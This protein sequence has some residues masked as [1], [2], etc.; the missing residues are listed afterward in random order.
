MTGK[1]ERRADP[2]SPER[3]VSAATAILDEGGADA[4]SFRALAARLSTGSGAIYWH[5]ADKQAL[6]TAATDQVIARAM[7][8]EGDGLSPDE[9]IRTL[10]LGVFDA[11]D[12]HPWVG[13]QLAGDPW[14]H[15]VL[16]ILEGLGAQVTA[17]GVP[18]EVRFDTATALLSF[19]LGLA[20]QY[21]VGS[22][23]FGGDM[24]RTTFLTE[25]AARWAELD[26]VEHPFVRQVAAQL[27]QHDD[28]QQFL[29]G[30]DLILAGIERS[31]R[32]PRTRC[33]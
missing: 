18:E 8:R 24:D 16:R 14:Q 1:G 13:A 30:V 10:A 23:R 26:P 20:G 11:I 3:I 2:L 25:I 5:V 32:S 6:L 9:A 33:S 21:A 28:R 4:L 17:L 22:S 31:R 15:A 27:P 7:A 29:A 19:I 12:A